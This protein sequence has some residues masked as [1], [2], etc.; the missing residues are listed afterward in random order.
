VE[1]CMVLVLVLVQ[2][3]VLVLLLPVDKLLGPSTRSR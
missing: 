3:L 1:Y 2:V